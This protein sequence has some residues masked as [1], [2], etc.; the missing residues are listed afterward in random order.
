MFGWNAGW[1]VG[2]RL[3]LCVPFSYGQRRQQASSAPGRGSRKRRR[4]IER[5]R[6]RACPVHRSTDCLWNGS[7]A[8]KHTFVLLFGWREPVPCL[9]CL[10]G[11]PAAPFSSASCAGFDDSPT[12]ARTDESDDEARFFFEP[13]GWCRAGSRQAACTHASPNAGRE[14]SSGRAPRS[15]RGAARPRGCLDRTLGCTH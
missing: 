14:S 9:A 6:E 4:S 7:T 12:A 8:P 13:K 5:E 10:A 2:M 15:G 1:L 11:A 3:A